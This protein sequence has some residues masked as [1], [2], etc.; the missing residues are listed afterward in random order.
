MEKE[1]SFMYSECVFVALIIQHATRLRHI[2]ISGSLALPHFSI[3]SHK[4]HDFR[5][6]GDKNLVNMKLCFHFL[7]K[8]CLQHFSLEETLSE[9]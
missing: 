9:M 6:G 7:Y 8:V 5:G 4:R 3:L 2:D 1:I